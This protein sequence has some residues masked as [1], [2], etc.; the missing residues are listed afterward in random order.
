MT[1]PAPSVHPSLFPQQ[2]WV[3]DRSCSSPATGDGQ[4]RKDSPVPVFGEGLWQHRLSINASMALQSH[5][6][7]LCIFNIKCICFWGFFLY[8][9]QHAPAWRSAS[10][11]ENVGS[12]VIP[13]LEWYLT[14]SSFII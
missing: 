8:I 5:S 4:A 7:Y 1:P 9:E 2:G 13:I 14:L 6:C 11:G 3:W 12:T 10:I